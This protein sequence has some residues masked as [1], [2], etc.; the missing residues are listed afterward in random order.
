M[1]N[2]FTVS[3]GLSGVSWSLIVVCRAVNE[4]CHQRPSWLCSVGASYSSQP[5]VEDQHEEVF[6]TIH[7]KTDKFAKE[8]KPVGLGRPILTI[9]MHILMIKK[10][11]TSYKRQKKYVERTK[12][13]WN[14]FEMVVQCTESRGE[15][16]LFKYFFKN[17]SFLFNIVWGRT[18]FYWHIEKKITF[19]FSKTNRSLGIMIKDQKEP[20]LMNASFLQL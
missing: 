20:T 11:D 15:L 2:S 9:L 19:C 7:V 10:P 12:M 8:I 14:I 3:P 4:Q 13:L 18:A 16:V 17:A 6:L 5:A 1:W